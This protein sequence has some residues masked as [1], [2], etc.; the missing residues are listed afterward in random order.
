M[1]GHGVELPVLPESHNGLG[2]LNLISIIFEIKILLNEFKR[3]TAP[4]PAD[5][6]L[7]FI[8]EPKAHTHP[9]M[10]AIFIKNIKI[11]VG[12]SIRNADGIGRPLQTIL[13]TLIAMGT[14][15]PY[16]PPR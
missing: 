14:P 11:L 16:V 5:I 12:R 4:R 3:G 7:L 15:N 8:E 9:Q 2:Y 6:N 10:Q 13:S 1:Y